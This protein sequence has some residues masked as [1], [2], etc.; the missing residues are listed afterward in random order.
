MFCPNC[1]TKLDENVSFCHSCGQ[2]IKKTDDAPENQKTEESYPAA[3]TATVSRRVDSDKNVIALI[4]FILSFVTSIPGIV[5]SAIGLKNARENGGINYKFAKA[6]LIIGIVNTAVLLVVFLV[7]II[8]AN[9][10]LFHYLG[11]YQDLEHSAFA[12]QIM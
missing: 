10:L 5:C 4:G 6:G 2:K 12:L 7:T 1:G 3:P 9:A 8:T 11:I